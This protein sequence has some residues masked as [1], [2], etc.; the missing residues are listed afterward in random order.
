MSRDHANRMYVETLASPVEEVELDIK[1]QNSRP[2]ARVEDKST[3][4]SFSSSVLILANQIHNT[5]GRDVVQREP[6]ISQISIHRYICR[7]RDQLITAR[8]GQCALKGNC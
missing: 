1:A 8:W 4:R 3:K 6:H 2:P 7:M 5:P